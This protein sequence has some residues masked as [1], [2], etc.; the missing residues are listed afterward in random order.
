MIPV[1]LKDKAFQPPE[2]AAY[3]LVAENG[4]FLVKNMPLYSASV[5]V[6]GNVLSVHDDH[7]QL[8]FGLIPRVLICKIF[9]LFRLAY[10]W[11]GGEAIVFLY[12]S[13]RDRTFCAQAPPQY[14]F[15][16]VNGNG[17]AHFSD[18]HV[19]YENCSRPNG[20]VKLGSVHSHGD[21]KAF[22]SC[23]DII[24]EKHD[25]GLHITIGH[26]H[27]TR[28]DFC[29]SFVVNGRRFAL[30]PGDIM[31]AYSTYTPFDP[32]ASWVKQLSC[33]DEQNG[34]VVRKRLRYGEH[35]TSRRMHAA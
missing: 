20:F 8:N 33:L 35:E 29:A 5:N 18:Y 17:V 27:S 7:L 4:T 21:G 30:N 31:A 9:G 13:L 34:I 2:D 32:P 14:V 10:M 19:V 16:R 22:H 3:Y 6:N 24:D 28:P 23:T 15:R 12:Y 26:V 1:Y 25:D 11:H